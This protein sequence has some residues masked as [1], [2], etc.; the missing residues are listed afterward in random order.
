MPRNAVASG[1]VDFVLSPSEVASELARIARDSYTTG[2]QS[3]PMLPPDGVARLFS[4][5][6]RS[7]NIDFS[8][9][10]AG[11]VERRIRRRMTMQKIETL[12][13]YLK[14]VRDDPPELDALYNDILIRVTNFF[15]DPA[16]FEALK[17]EVFPTLFKEEN[18]P[19]RVWVPGCATGE[20]VYSIAIVGLEAME[21][22]RF[23][24]PIQI[25]GT[26]VS[27]AAI[28]QARAGLYSQTAVADVDKTRLHRF[29]TATNGSFQVSKTLRD[30]CIFAKQNVTKDL[31][32]SRL[33][34][35]SC[36]NVMI[37]L[38]APLQRK[39]MNIFHY[40][41]KPTGYLL[42]GNS[43]TVGNFADLFGIA[44]RKHKIYQKKYAAGRIGMQFE[45]ARPQPKERGEKPMEHDLPAADGLRTCFA[46]LI[47]FFSRDTCPQ[48]C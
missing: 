8:H 21:A 25:F 22:A 30:C 48:E 23:T 7:H 42:L 29:F 4:M 2:G 33:D 39:V 10:K 20:E 31:P 45:P 5:L 35:I 32:F 14:L 28:E 1:A 15:R 44:D 41:L 24:C 36:R 34:L 12:D 11:T 43:E 26:D 40:A 3:L 47:V 16:V 13:D 46:R 17:T 18:Q 38:G 9:Y 19:L 27:D 37:Y 6:Q